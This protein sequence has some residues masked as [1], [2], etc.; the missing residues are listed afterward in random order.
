[1]QLD[2]KDKYII[3]KTNPYTVRMDRG[4]EALEKLTEVF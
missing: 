1:M 4:K 3:P 2:G